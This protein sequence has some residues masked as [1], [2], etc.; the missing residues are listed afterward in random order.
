MAL[1]IRQKN[2]VPVAKWMS[3]NIECSKTEGR[4]VMSSAGEGG[5]AT[6]LLNHASKPSENADFNPDTH[7]SFCHLAS[8]LERFSH[9]S[10]SVFEG[11]GGAGRLVVP[12]APD[13]PEGR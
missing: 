13:L 8:C 9:P 5:I 11:F 4:F 6:P 12:Q 2:P 1:P 10:S 3:L 7:L